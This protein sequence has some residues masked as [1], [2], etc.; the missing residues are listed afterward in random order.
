MFDFFRKK[1]SKSDNVAPVVNA[2]TEKKETTSKPKN[3]KN[4]K[5]INSVMEKTGWDRKYARQQMK[6]AKENCGIRFAE[7]DK[8]NFHT[9]AVEDQKDA[10][11]EI[12]AKKEAAAIR[13]K[14]RIEKIMFRTDWTYEEAENHLKQ[15]KK[16]TGCKNKE[17]FEYKMYKLPLTEVAAHYEDSVR[18][19]EL[20]IQKNFENAVAL[21][22]EKTGWTPEYA[23]EKIRD[24]QERTGCT[25]KEY[26]MYR[27]YDLT[28]EQQMDYFLICHQKLLRRKFEVSRLFNDT[29]LDKEKTNLYFPEC[30]RRPWCANAK[31]TL[32]EFKEIFKNTDRVIYKPNDGHRGIGIEAYTINEDNIEEVYNK[33]K[34]YPAGV[35]EEFIVQHPVM[36]SLSPSSVNSLRFVTVSSNTEPVT[37][38]GSMVDIV[39]SLVRI[40][41]GDSIVD[42]L[43]S[44]GMAANVDLATGTIETN[45]ADRSGFMYEKHPETGVV[46]KGFKIPFFE[47]GMEMV[48]EAIRSKNVQGYLGWDL[49]ITEEG[50]KLLEVNLGP[51]ADGLQTTYAQEHRGMKH[52]M[53]KYL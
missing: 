43:H 22:T 37:P 31:V 24:A 47:E 30:V 26:Y 4:E 36:A 8:Y 19:K 38:D 23:A 9:V 27:F 46:L 28:D 25:A 11:Q 20:G 52:V 53:F 2:E 10:Y 12:L 39:Y 50:P 40:G 18:K 45:G 1:K 16:I 49:A 41:R 42:N 14:N 44:G 13:K 51:G 48:K 21:T 6:A 7:Y 34:D 15:T 32:D 35:V 5:R 3:E 29:L 33:L 17:Y